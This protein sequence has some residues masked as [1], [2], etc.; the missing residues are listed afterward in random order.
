MLEQVELL[1]SEQC[2]LTLIIKVLL[3]QKLSSL[4]VLSKVVYL[5]SAC[6]VLA[7]SKHT[8]T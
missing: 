1:P 8:A 3:E 2:Y 5:V 7:V 4:A 6:S